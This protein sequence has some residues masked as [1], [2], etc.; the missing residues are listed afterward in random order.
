[1]RTRELLPR[2]HEPPLR[3]IPMLQITANGA[4]ILQFGCSVRQQ[5]SELFLQVS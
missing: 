5:T 2:R 1:M 4:A 3:F